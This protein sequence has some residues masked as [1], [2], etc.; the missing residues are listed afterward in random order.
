[1]FPS[2]INSASGIRINKMGAMMYLSPRI[3]KGMLAQKYI[4]DDPFNNFPNFKIKHVESSFVT[5]SLRAQGA[6]NSEFIYYQGIQGPIK[7]WEIDYTGKEEFKPEYIDKDA[8]KY[9]S[10]KL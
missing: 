9:L 4:L 5:D 8:S 7:I 10:W 1:T 6:S 3:M 2:L